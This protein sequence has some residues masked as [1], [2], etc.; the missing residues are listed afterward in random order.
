MP[1]IRVKTDR[2]EADEIE[3]LHQF[4]VSSGKLGRSSKRHKKKRLI[5]FVDFSAYKPTQDLELKA[6]NLYAQRKPSIFDNVNDFVRRDTFVVVFAHPTYEI[7]YN[8]MP[9]SNLLNIYCSNINKKLLFK[10]T[11]D[12]MR[13]KLP[14]AMAFRVQLNNETPFNIK[15]ATYDRKQLG[16][17][18]A[19]TSNQIKELLPLQKC[20]I[21]LNILS[22]RFWTV[23]P[24]LLALFF[25][26]PLQPPISAAHNT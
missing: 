26:L 20:V 17:I 9:N 11:N 18:I 2:Q 21:Y 14:N 8:R 10:D 4:G 16:L 13:N 3:R 19:L 25:N 5:A 23:P 1:K 24:D 15:S 7:V 6:Q 12:E 22:S